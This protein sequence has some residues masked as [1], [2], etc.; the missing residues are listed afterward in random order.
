MHARAQWWFVSTTPRD[1]TIDDEQFGRRTEARRTLSS[2]PWSGAK[3]YVA[4]Q[5]SGG[6]SNVHIVPN[7]LR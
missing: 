1:D 2:Q 4:F 7:S 6:A 3:P 5:Y